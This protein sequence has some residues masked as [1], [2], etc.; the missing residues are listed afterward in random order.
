[1]SYIKIFS[2][3]VVGV[4]EGSDCLDKVRTNVGNGREVE[5][6]IA[7]LTKFKGAPKTFIIADKGEICPD[8]NPLG[9]LW[10]P[11]AQRPSFRMITQGKYPKDYP[12]GAVVHFTAGRSDQD[13]GFNS[14][15]WGLGQGYAFLFIGRDGTLWQ[16]HP[17]DEWGRHA[18]ASGWSGLEGEVSD[19]LVGIEIAAAGR[20]KPVMIAGQRKFAPWFAYDKEGNLIHPELC[21]SESEMRYEPD[22]ENEDNQFS[23]W[24]QKFTQQQ[25]E[26]LIKTLLWLKKNNSSVFNFDYVLGHD[27]VARPHGRKNDPGAALSMTM[28]ELRDLLKQRYREE[29]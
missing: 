10:I 29:N 27:E 1:M 4:F 8:I 11:Y 9:E 2:D 13:N 24:Y 6:L 20:C 21:F 5:R 22:D 16:A 23:G 7:A 12:V 28:Q 17:L 18:G 15:Q 14:M 26:T 3:G 25:E 19:D